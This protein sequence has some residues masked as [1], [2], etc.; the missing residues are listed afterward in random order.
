MITTRVE[1]HGD[2]ANAEAEQVAGENLQ[3]AAEFLAEK[4]REEIGLPYPPASRP[5]EPPRKRSGELQD[6]VEAESDGKGGARVKVG[7]P[8]AGY[9]EVGLNRPFVVAT[10]KKYWTELKRVAAGGG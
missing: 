2:E 6:S 1:F 7:A 5:G 4:I 10:A 8:Y 3:A 9:L